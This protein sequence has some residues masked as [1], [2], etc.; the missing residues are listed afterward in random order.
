[1]GSRLPTANYAVDGGVK[2]GPLEAKF[3][4]TD[5][6]IRLALLECLQEDPHGLDCPKA[7]DI[8]G[9][10]PDWDLIQVSDLSYLFRDAPMFRADVSGWRISASASTFRM[11]SGAR[12]FSQHFTCASADG[13]PSSCKGRR[14]DADVRPAVLSCLNEDPSGLSCPRSEREY[15]KMGRWDTSFVTSLAG[16]FRGAADFAGDI[17]DWDTSAVSTMRFIF[18]GASSFNG[19]IGRWNTGRVTN[20]DSAFEKALSFNGSLSGWDV[21]SATSMSA[22][23]SGARHFLGKGLNNWDVS[24]VRTMSFMFHEAMSLNVDLSSWNVGNVVDME[25][26]F[27]GAL[28]FRG[29]GLATWD[30]SRVESMAHMFAGAESFVADL[31]A[32]DVLQCTNFFS[33]FAEN[34]TW[35]GDVRRWRVSAGLDVADIL[36]SWNAGFLERWTC[37]ECTSSA[38]QCSQAFAC[39]A[40]N[41]ENCPRDFPPG[42]YI[43]GCPDFLGASGACPTGSVD[44]SP[45]P[46]PQSSVCVAGSL[47]V[48]TECT[49]HCAPGE[50]LESGFCVPCPAGLWSAGGDYPMGLS[51]I[52]ASTECNLCAENHHVWNG[53]CVECGPGTWP[54]P[55]GDDLYAGVNTECDPVRCTGSERVVNHTCEPCVNGTFSTPGSDARGGDTYCLGAPVET[56]VS[57]IPLDDV[58]AGQNFTCFL[59]RTG[60]VRCF[61]DEMVSPYRDEPWTT[62]KNSTGFLDF[63]SQG[64]RVIQ[65]AARSMGAGACVLLS[66]GDVKCWGENSRGQ[67]G[68]GHLYDRPDVR[69]DDL[70]G[71]HFGNG[72]K[73]VAIAVGA[74]HT[75]AV[76]QDGSLKCWGDNTDGQLGF[77]EIVLPG[78][79]NPV[80][81]CANAQITPPTIDFGLGRSVV[82]VSAGL[83]HTCAVLDNGSLMCWGSNLHGALGVQGPNVEGGISRV[84]LGVRRSVTD[85]VCGGSFTCALLDNGDVK[86]WGALAGLG[87]LSPHDSSAHWNA[88]AYGSGYGDDDFERVDL[89]PPIELGIGRKAVRLAAGAVHACAVLDNG[90]LKCWGSNA[91]GQ[92]GLEDTIDRW[93]ISQMGDALPKIDLGEGAVVTSVSCGARSTCA[94]LN[95]GTARCWGHAHKNSLGSGKSRDT[96][97]SIGTMGDSSSPLAM[98]GEGG[99]DAPSCPT[100][101]IP[102]YT[103][104]ACVACPLGMTSDGWHCFCSE[105]HHVGSSGWA[106]EQCPEGTVRAAG[107]LPYGR[108]TICHIPCDTGYFWSESLGACEILFCSA[109][110]YFNGSSCELCDAGTFSSGLQT[111]NIE[112]SYVPGKYNQCL[113]TS[114]AMRFLEVTKVAA[115]LNFLCVL[116][117]SGKV[118]CVGRHPRAAGAEGRGIYRGS[119]PDEGDLVPFLGTGGRRVVDI[120]VSKSADAPH[121]CAVLEDGAV[122]CWGSEFNPG[123]GVGVANFTKGP[124]LQ[125]DVDLGFNQKAVAVAVGNKFS[126]ALLNNGYVKCWG[127]NSSGQLGTGDTIARVGN[128]G[129]M[130]DNLP[131][132]SFG[133]GVRAVTIHAGHAFACANLENGEIKCWGDS[134][135]GIIGFGN[136][137]SITPSAK[138]FDAGFDDVFSLALGNQSLCASGFARIDCFG[139]E[140]FGDGPVVMRA[141]KLSIGLHSLCVIT[142]NGSIAC[143]HESSSDFTLVDLPGS[144]LA[145]EV[146]DGYGIALLDDRSIVTW[147]L[148]QPDDYENVDVGSE[149][150]CENSTLMLD[151][152]LGACLPCAPGFQTNAFGDTCNVPAVIICPEGYVS[153]DD[154]A[155]CSMCQVGYRVGP[156]STCEACPLGTRSLGGDHILNG[157]TKCSP[158]ICPTQFYVSDH[159][160]VRCPRGTIRNARDSADGSDTACLDPAVL[161]ASCACHSSGGE[162]A[163]TCFEQETRVLDASGVPL[164]YET[165]PII[166]SMDVLQWVESCNA[167]ESIA[168]AES[169]GNCTDA[170]PHGQ[171]CVATCSDGFVPNGSRT[172]FAGVLDDTLQCV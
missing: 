52:P 115:G 104:S 1:M 99:G 41:A 34:S 94:L 121:G 153:G 80:S 72:R 111:V 171:M 138:L 145:V 97:G 141:V 109:Y 129:E 49:G 108:S 107:D 140:I 53:V 96:G 78:A 172:C 82:S 124:G 47:T 19:E 50:H 127:E 169:L 58:A 33:M 10:L 22:M 69:G 26:M 166:E 131:F 64:A 135:G 73:A 35:N 32:W 68:L 103:I 130:G 48:L 149:L 15:G 156:N 134:A 86:C 12:A 144:A 150:F 168:N 9:W 123:F 154:S 92:L 79:E 155:P 132:V 151:T 89:L 160:C 133:E 167:T 37:S 2:Y 125:D 31:S 27:K 25:S 147:L 117:T 164:E 60:R 65:V 90:S 170:L 110:E 54:R 139:T 112:L 81:E 24:E 7:E 30:T 161:P 98:G 137:T 84:N 46:L 51:G 93:S 36:Q 70:M 120:A 45:S 158:M 95:D 77:E 142:S 57:E 116:T 6:D 67:L 148:S 114:A 5:D 8:Y 11:F 162:F 43:A 143:M 100:G 105:N 44:L 29:A 159:R 83:S 152:S 122:A 59:G 13:P 61:G 23:F 126:C 71:V 42:G 87:Q 157:E 106:C 165:A 88:S 39:C 101:L 14:G 38:E 91:D 63:G 17:S 62:L 75:C 128:S 3:Y 163:C 66:T 28:A 4:R 21:S 40:S 136:S 85:V 118:K 102:D 18:Y 16:L 20:F 113:G 76:L 146:V 56:M 74:A 119:G 55:A